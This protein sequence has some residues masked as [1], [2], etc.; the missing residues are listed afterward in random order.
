MGKT[1]H[2]SQREAKRL[3][4][5]LAELRRRD[6]GRQQGWSADYPGGTRLGSRTLPRDWLSGRIEA[7]RILGHA[8]VVTSAVRSDDQVDVFFTAVN[9]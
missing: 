4:K 3:R 1:N 6:E 8:V 2:I 7:A 9:Q 5:E